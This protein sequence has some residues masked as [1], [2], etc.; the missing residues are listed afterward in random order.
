MRALVI[1]G[2]GLV[3]AALACGLRRCRYDVVTTTRRRDAAGEIFL[4]LSA[5]DPDSLP[6]A[7]IVFLCAAMTRFTA[8][9]AAPRLAQQVNCDGPAAIAARLAAKGT[10]VVFL[11]TAA[12]FDGREPLM[13]ADR[14]TSGASV[15]GRCKAE[16]ERR[17]LALG[18]LAAV[19]RLTKLVTPHQALFQAWM[20]A[21]KTGQ[22]VE[23]FEDQRIAPLL[24]AHCVDALAAIS[25]R[26]AGGIYQISAAADVSYQDIARHLARRL[27]V[28]AGLV[29][30]ATAA[31][32][33]IPAE[34]ILPFTSLDVSRMSA[35]SGFQPPPPLQV[36]DEALFQ[37]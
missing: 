23:A 1:G 6:G 35:L 28:D 22:P 3:G 27:G 18:S 29:H 37:P 8:C 30:P 31:E 36:I 12:V 33:G 11:S 15:Y 19:L 32:R 21:L 9:R 26:G 7:D 16:A 13:A 25:A 5:P 20:A 24:P 17:I 14:A 4:D 2:D 10:R 34:E